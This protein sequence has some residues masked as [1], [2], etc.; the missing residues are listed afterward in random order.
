[1]KYIKYILLAIL[2]SLVMLIFFNTKSNRFSNDKL[3]PSSSEDKETGIH[4]LIVQR[5]NVI[6]QPIS[7]SS[8]KQVS[9][10]IPP[11]TSSQQ[12][13]RYAL[14]SSYWEQQINAI[15]NLFCFQRWASSVGLTVVEPFVNMSELKFSG[16]LL[17]DND[18]LSDVLRLRDYIDIDYYN[19]WVKKSD[20]L[21]LEN[22]KDFTQ[23]STKKVI[24]ALI[25]YGVET[26]GTFVGGES[27]SHSPCLEQKTV[28]FN[29]H[30]R[31]FSK[32]QFEIIKV[33]C[34]SFSEYVISPE[35]FLPI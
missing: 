20:V 22:W 16:E 32:L 31:L 33:V 25:S 21:P 8:S 30:Q 27:D 17:L 7:V 13:H 3:F 14:C 6:S 26:G 24:V 2:G 29:D 35:K 9:S 28:F 18:K 34:V 10:S 19:K 4:D 23:F 11:T 15:L 1:M 5:R 12:T